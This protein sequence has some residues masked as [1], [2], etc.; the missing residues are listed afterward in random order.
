MTAD[1]CLVAGSTGMLGSEICRL[2]SVRGCAVRA[3]VRTSS[4][5]DKVARLKDL[6]AEIID[7]DLKNPGSLKAACRGAGTVISTASSTVAR[8]QGDSIESV[9]LQG[10]LNLVEAAEQAGVGHFILVS[11][12][13]IDL[14][15]PLQSAKRAVEERVRRSR[16]SYTIL[17]PTCF[18]EVW[19]G[20]ALGFDV[21]SATARIY[22]DGQRKTSWI[23]FQDVARF[24]TAAVGNVQA[25]NT[26]IK[27]GGPDAMSPL[28]V[29]R[30]AEQIA[31]KTIHVQHVPEEALRAQ[32]GA[33]TDSLQKSFAALMLYYARGDAIDMT[34]ALR[35]LP[36]NQR[37]SVH[38]YL[39]AS[40]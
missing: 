3:L 27:L 36:V 20:P 14:D 34:Q 12:P 25:K 32:H 7:G 19:L 4:N 11:F 33:A 38:E 22:G 1:L 37:K 29:V 18:M 15:F 16:M 21:A 23:S 24:V 9:D 13:T 31:G 30:L 8:Q 5:P 17:Q 26:V 28:E 40:I 39:Q 10:Q 6:G 35:I 2:L